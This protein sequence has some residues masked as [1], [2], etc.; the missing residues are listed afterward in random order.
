M[1]QYT[2]HDFTMTSHQLQGALLIRQPSQAGIDALCHPR[3]PAR[4]LH[5]GLKMD[6]LVCRETQN[7]FKDLALRHIDFSIPYLEQPQERIEYFKREVLLDPE[8]SHLTWY[9]DGWAVD[10]FLRIL[11]HRP[12]PMSN[13]QE[14]DLWGTQVFPMSQRPPTVRSDNQAIQPEDAQELDLWGTQVFPISQRPSTVRS[15][16][17]VIQPEDAQ[18]LERRGTQHDCPRQRSSTVCSGNQ[19]TQPKDAQVNTV[20]EEAPITSLPRIAV[21]SAYLA[22]IPGLHRFDAVLTQAGL[23]TDE[24]LDHFLHMAP[25]WREKFI[26]Q[27]LTENSTLFERMVILEILEGLKN[28]TL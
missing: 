20:D 18:E 16:S 5:A 15:G 14:L 3:T 27:A 26:T 11:Y 22:S 2:T 10:V 21:L 17:Q 6:R 4:Y 12:R 28:E 8:L 7:K 25:T 9:E 24:H 19:V 23:S 13:L 1:T